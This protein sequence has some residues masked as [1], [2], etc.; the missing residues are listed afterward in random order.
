MKR[1]KFKCPYC[2]C[3]TSYYTKITG[4]QYYNEFGEERGYDIDTE[5]KSRYCFVCDRRVPRSKVA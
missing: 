5:S 1:N 3:E 2:G 4:R